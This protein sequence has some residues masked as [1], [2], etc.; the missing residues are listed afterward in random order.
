M[1]PGMG[2][3]PGSRFQLLDDITTVSL[4]G[5]AVFCLVSLGEC[6]CHTNRDR[7]VEDTQ[8]VNDFLLKFIVLDEWANEMSSLDPTV[9]L[10]SLVDKYD[11][12]RPPII[13]I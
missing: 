4:G 1:I 6:S 9:S 11:A 8:Q 10:L 13:N 12:V 7:E 2:R 3:I 5:S